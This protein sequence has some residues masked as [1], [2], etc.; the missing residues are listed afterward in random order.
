[1]N[2]LL[3]LNLLMGVALAYA[4]KREYPRRQH[5]PTFRVLAGTAAPGVQVQARSGSPRSRES[6]CIPSAGDR[7]WPLRRWRP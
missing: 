3:F 2:Q 7:A 6:G 4:A 5:A 1:M